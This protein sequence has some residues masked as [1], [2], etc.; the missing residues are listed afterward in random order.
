MNQHIEY[1][2]NLKFVKWIE[3][4]SDRLD[5]WLKQNW[6]QSI[7]AKSIVLMIIWV[8]GLIPTWIAIGLWL[9]ISPVGFW[10]SFA[11]I[12]VILLFFGSVQFVIGICMFILSLGIIAGDF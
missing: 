1:V 9:L 5:R 6:I 4:L 3:N 12:S 11:M 8:V 10:Q 7:I 2:R